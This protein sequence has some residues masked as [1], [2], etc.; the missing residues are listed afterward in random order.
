MSD[1]VTVTD[2]LVAEARH[3]VMCAGDE[4]PLNENDAFRMVL[5]MGWN[6][7]LATQPQDRRVAELEADLAT[8]QESLEAEAERLE[9]K[10]SVLEDTARSIQVERD[11]A[12]AREEQLRDALER[13]RKEAV[14]LLQNSEGCAVNHYGEDFA[15][16]GMPGWLID[17]RIAVEASGKALTPPQ[18]LSKRDGEVL[19]LRKVLQRAA[20]HNVSVEGADWWA[21]LF[22][23]LKDTTQAAQSA[24]DAIR[25]DER[26]KMARTLCEH[27]AAGDTPQEWIMPGVFHHRRPTPDTAPRLNEHTYSACKASSI[28]TTQGE[29]DDG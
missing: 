28:R 27:C 25:A 17:A 4:G 9:H 21:D 26:E 2:E 19:A 13:L 29:K 16:Y 23:A 1:A 14:L 7:A 8:A 18:A 20:D 6:A 3:Q 10:V 22:K 11:Q 24:E 5:E 15:L 12:L